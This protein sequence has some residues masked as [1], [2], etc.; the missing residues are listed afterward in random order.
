MGGAAI[1]TSRING[2]IASAPVSVWWSILG[3][4]PNSSTTPFKRGS[5]PTPALVSPLTR[6]NSRSTHAR[7]R[8]D[9]GTARR[10][11]TVRQLDPEGVD[12]EAEGPD[13]AG[14][15]GRV[16]KLRAGCGSRAS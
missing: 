8:S 14:K 13:L 15:A 1:G 6:E 12:I 9:A 10:A 3:E 7:S 11:P 5:M 4:M 2:R 16:R